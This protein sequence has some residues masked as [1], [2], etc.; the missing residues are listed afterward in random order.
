MACSRP[1]VCFDTCGLRDI[2]DHKVN[3]YLAHSFD[4]LDFATG[5]KWVLD[6]ENQNHFLLARK[7]LKDFFQRKLLLKNI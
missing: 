5:I 1:V 4:A 2:V 3:G 7:K 6:N